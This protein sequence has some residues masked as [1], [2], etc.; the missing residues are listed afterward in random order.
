MYNGNKK[1]KKGYLGTDEMRIR[2]RDLDTFEYY[3]RNTNFIPE[4]YDSYK[5]FN[6][7][8]PICQMISFSPRFQLI[9]LSGS[10]GP[11]Q[12]DRNRVFRHARTGYKFFFLV[13]AYFRYSSLCR[14]LVNISVF[15]SDTIW[16]R[17]LSFF[18]LH[19]NIDGNKYTI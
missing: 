4:T 3:K 1:K 17:F 2:K 13:E 12:E 18:S 5:W 7:C 16:L 8:A 6:I 9:L 11:V 19:S 15:P 10:T 14:R